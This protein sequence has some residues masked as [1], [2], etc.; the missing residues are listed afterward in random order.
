MKTSALGS[1]LS[2]RRSKF[3]SDPNRGGFFAVAIEDVVDPRISFFGAKARL[4]VRRWERGIWFEHLKLVRP[5]QMRVDARQL[6]GLLRDHFRR[7]INDPFLLALGKC[8]SPLFK[9]CFAV[10]N[11]LPPPTKVS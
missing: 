11:F 2:I 7:C 8:R 4:E 5:D 10:V 1:G 9:A 3:I 6:K